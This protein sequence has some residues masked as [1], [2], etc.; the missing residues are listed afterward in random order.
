MKTQI[1]KVIDSLVMM[2]GFI[3]LFT[4]CETDATDVNSAEIQKITVADESA[5]DRSA[6]AVT[7]D[8]CECLA[9]NFANGELSDPEKAAILFMREEEKLARDVYLAL[10]EKWNSKVFA[11]IAK[12]EQRHMDA[13]LCLIQ[14]YG[15]E[16]PVAGFNP[17]EFITMGDLYHNLVAK[18]NE[19]LIAAMTVGADIEVLDISD[20][21]LRKADIFENDDMLAVFNELEKGSRNHLRAF[22]RN[23]GNLDAT[24][25]LDEALMSQEDFDNIINSPKE[26]GGGICGTCLGGGQGN[27]PGNGTGV[28][29]GSGPHG[30][31]GG[32]G[33]GSGTCEG[34]GPNGNGGSGGNGTGNC[35][36]TGSHGTGGTGGGGNSGG[37]GGGTGGTGGG[38]NS[39]G[40]GGGTGGNGGGNG[41]GG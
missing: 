26:T 23:L 39:G 27:G 36:G 12:S 2:T 3:L 11:N 18:G 22:I 40:N 30:N 25:E 32:N 19:S 41:H 20:L 4:R 13:V 5:V 29:D 7:M 34:T 10:Y 28:C 33:S 8:V 31:G 1:L 15:L 24:Y 35:D 37:N 17:G 38:G 6:G 9:S 16:D 14:R 21:I